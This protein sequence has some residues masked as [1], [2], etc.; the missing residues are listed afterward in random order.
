MRTYVADNPHRYK[1]PMRVAQARSDV[2]KQR[3]AITDAEKVLQQSRG[4]LAE[5][6]AQEQAISTEEMLGAC[7]RLSFRRG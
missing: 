1:N 4:R 3:A 6:E 7:F 2:F 5:L